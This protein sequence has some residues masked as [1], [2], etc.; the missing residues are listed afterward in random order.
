M[1]FGKGRREADNGT[2][3][4]GE[5]RGIRLGGSDPQQPP[6]G[7]GRRG[8]RTSDTVDDEEA[9]ID[10]PSSPFDDLDEFTPDDEG[11]PGERRRDPLRKSW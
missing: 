6:T 1:R 8:R 4:G 2:I 7:L 11:T 9:L 3:D 5:G 10:T